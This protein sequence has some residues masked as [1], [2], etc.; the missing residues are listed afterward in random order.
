MLRKLLNLP[1]LLWRLYQ[2]FIYEYLTVGEVRA[3]ITGRPR[4]IRVRHYFNLFATCFFIVRATMAIAAYK[5]PSFWNVYTKVDK[6]FVLLTNEGPCDL[7]ACL[8]GLAFFL[9]LL[10]T[11]SQLYFGFTHSVIHHMVY[12]LF[13]GVYVEKNKSVFFPEIANSRIQRQIDKIVSSMKLV[14]FVLFGVGK[15]A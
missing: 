13:I 2:W 5:I 6:L 1:R 4:H 11:Y 10:F 7:F 15:V 8:M 9:Y 3:L 12:D 14:Y